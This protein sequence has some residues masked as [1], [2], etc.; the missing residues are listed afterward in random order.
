LIRTQDWSGRTRIIIPGARAQ[1]SAASVSK[2][3]S[4]PAVAPWIRQCERLYGSDDLYVVS[5]R[6]VS[7]REINAH[8][9]VGKGREA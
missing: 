8:G 6:Q 2:P 5:K 9:C 3:G 1:P 7:T 4:Q